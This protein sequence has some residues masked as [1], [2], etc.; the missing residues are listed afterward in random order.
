[1]F[2]GELGG[3]T[4]KKIYRTRVVVGI[5]VGVISGILKL[6]GASGIVIAIIAY[7]ATHYFF[8]LKYKDLPSRHY[9]IGLPE[10][11]GLWLTMW[12]VLFTL[13]AG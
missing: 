7:V 1:M 11:I 5:V 2:R 12:S 4:A 13:L 3:E 10:Y 8:K 6:V 9:A